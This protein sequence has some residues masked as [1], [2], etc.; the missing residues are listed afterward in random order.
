M[1][2]KGKYQNKYTLQI[3]TIE[4][5]EMSSLVFSVLFFKRV[6]LTKNELSKKVFLV[7][8]FTF[9]FSPVIINGIGLMYPHS[10]KKQVARLRSVK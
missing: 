7:F 6:H 2:L 10:H 5:Y 4:T 1:V 8:V 3:L 9:L